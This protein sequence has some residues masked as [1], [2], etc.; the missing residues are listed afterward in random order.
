[1]VAPRL[2][3]KA[4]TSDTEIATN[5]EQIKMLLSTKKAAKGGVA[6]QIE[7]VTKTMKDAKLMHKQLNESMAL[8]DDE[9]DA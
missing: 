8:A 5:L 4:K 6:K 1:M 7:A 3:S 9:E 2:L